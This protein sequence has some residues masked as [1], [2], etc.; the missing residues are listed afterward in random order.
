MTEHGASA[1]TLAET[2]PI[3]R[4]AFDAARAPVTRCLHVV[5]A[6]ELDQRRGRIDRLDHVIGQLIGQP[7]QRRRPMLELGEA[8]QVQIA[9][10]LVFALVERQPREL[11]HIDASDAGAGLARRQPLDRG[12]Q[13]SRQACVFLAEIDGGDDDRC[14][15]ADRDRLRRNGDAGMGLPQPAR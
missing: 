10:R 12:K 1:T 6:G 2:L 8:K 3:K 7:R 5:A 9:P 11:E 13:G 14:R 15:L 4:R